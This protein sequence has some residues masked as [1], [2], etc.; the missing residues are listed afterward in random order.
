M[1]A[2]FLVICG[3]SL[4]FFAT[5][6]VECSLSMKKSHNRSRKTLAVRK[7]P[8]DQVV[9]S[10]CGRRV[11]IHLEQQMA[12]FLSEKRGTIAILAILASTFLFSSPA[13]AQDNSS[14]PQSSAASDASI[15]P[16]VAKQLEAMQKRIDQLEQQLQNRPSQPPTDG[17][18]TPA[19]SVAEQSSGVYTPPAGKAENALAQKDPNEKPAPFSFADFSWL[20]GNS[21]HQGSATRYQVLHARNSCRFELH[22]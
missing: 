18:M 16:A 6:L 12:Q 21:P 5:F 15:P 20:N 19:H 2:F 22:L 8:Q 4:V 14:N 3:I 7:L 1:T 13:H 11:F 9:D 10:A 17:T